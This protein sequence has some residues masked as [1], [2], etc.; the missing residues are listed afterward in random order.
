MSEINCNCVICANE[1]NPNELSNLTLSKINVTRFKICA[2]CLNNCD[3]A[4]DYKVARDI[5]NSYI[6]FASAKSL[7]LEVNDLIKSK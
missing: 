3:P 6:S 5:I 7:L 1:F 4:N 2:S